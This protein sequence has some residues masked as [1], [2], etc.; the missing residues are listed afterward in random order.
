MTLAARDA[1]L[2]RLA[3]GRWPA[4]PLLDVLDLNPAADV[5]DIGAGDGALLAEFQ[6]RGHQGRLVGLDPHPG[7]GVLQGQAEALPFPNAS[8]D[9]VLMIRMLPHVTDE[10]EALAEARRVLRPGGQLVLAAHG[11]DH[12]RETWLALGRPTSERGP[13]AALREALAAAGLTALRLDARIPVMV[14]ADAARELVGAYGLSLGVNGARFPV[15]DT[16][17][18]ALYQHCQT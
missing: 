4:A 17:H 16:L 10:R 1:L 6:R 2:S 5:L 14:N 11:A 3:G 12:L 9:V 15:Q 13:E 7:A 8:F 18:L